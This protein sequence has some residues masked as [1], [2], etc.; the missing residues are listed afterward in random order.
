MAYC[1]PE[2]LDPRHGDD[3]P[4]S[5][6]YSLAAVGFELVTGQPVRSGGQASLDE[7]TQSTSR[8]PH[9]LCSE[10]PLE[11][12]AVLRH[13][14]APDPDRRYPSAAD[15]A[16]DLRRFAEDRPVAVPLEKPSQTL[17]ATARRQR[18]F[19]AV[20]C[21]TLAS[22][23]GS[24][25]VG[26]WRGSIGAA[27]RFHMQLERIVHESREVPG[28]LSPELE[29]EFRALLVEITPATAGRPL[30]SSDRAH[31]DD[32]GATS[33]SNPSAVL[34]SLAL[35]ATRLDELGPVEILDWL[36]R[37]RDWPTEDLAAGAADLDRL[38]GEFVA[39][40]GPGRDRRL[41]SAEATW[42]AAARA[43][44][45]TW[46][47]AQFLERS[48][49]AAEARGEVEAAR[50]DLE[51]AWGVLAGTSAAVVESRRPV[52]ELARLARL[53]GDQGA[54][55][56]ARERLD[57]IVTTWTTQRGADDPLTLSACAEFARVDLA[58]DRAHPREDEV[59]RADE[60]LERATALETVQGTW[61]L[62]L[63]LDLAEAHWRL[64]ELAA[65]TELLRRGAALPEAPT[66]L[67]GDALQTW[68]AAA[69]PVR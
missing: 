43:T 49:W 66:A 39:L 24:L 34:L 35:A 57:L 31:D 23:F 27:D 20:A 45:R 3:D 29:G 37:A 46:V 12:S 64:G 54:L 22:I 32:P 68:R 14:L 16:A 60:V 10:V 26:H 58:L 11:L 67:P 38:A 47:R 21:L 2:R 15:F 33:N 41:A 55:E 8:W 62:G 4:R 48:A 42:R 65:G 28:G 56:V 40:S 59:V 7:A 51:A 50:M 13:A 52:L 17:R 1:A 18:G 19:I 53:Q 69:A 44:Q 25:A 30:P 9:H 63:A 36:T 6:V 5:D 61:R